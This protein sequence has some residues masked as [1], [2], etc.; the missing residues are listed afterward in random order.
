MVMRFP[1]KS[2][3]LHYTDQSSDYSP[4]TIAKNLFNQIEIGVIREL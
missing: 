3:N 2:R 4:K 1:K